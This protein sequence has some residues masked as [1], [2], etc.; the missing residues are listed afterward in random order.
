MS[1]IDVAWRSTTAEPDWLRSSDGRLA[2]GSP[3]ASA[4]MVSLFTDRRAGPDD[5]LTDGS[6]DRRGWWG[7][8]FA[9]QRIGSRLWLLKRRKRTAETLRLAQDYAREALQWLISDGIAARVDVAAEWA[10]TSR[11]HI[12]VTIYRSDGAR[13]AVAADWAWS[14]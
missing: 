4:V 9:D 10:T 3:L 1:F 7:D 8:A 5:V 13:V 2:Q 6:T 14:T 11:M 12:A